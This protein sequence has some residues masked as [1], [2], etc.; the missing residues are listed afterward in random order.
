MAQPTYYDLSG[1]EVFFYHPIDAMEALELGAVTTKPGKS[2]PAAKEQEPAAELE[3]AREEDGTYRA[4]DPATPEVNEA[5]VQ[6]EAPKKAP[7]R[8]RV[9]K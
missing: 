1:K 5:Y 2:A 3:R 9:A 4:D 7:P 8:R 6:P